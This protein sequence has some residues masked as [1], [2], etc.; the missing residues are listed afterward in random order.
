MLGNEQTIS[1]D[2]ESNEY[3]ERWLWYMKKSQKMKLA[4]PKHKELQ[5]REKEE[6]I[7]RDFH[8][9]VSSYLKAKES[10]DRKSVV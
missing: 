10:A 2:V 1:L 5:R 8:Y 7:L 3:L 4:K 9:V 6:N